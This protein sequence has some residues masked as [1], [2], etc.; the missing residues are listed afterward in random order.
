MH[1]VLHHFST[2]WKQNLIVYS[3]KWFSLQPLYFHIC[4]VSIIFNVCFLVTLVVAISG[5]SYFLIVSDRNHLY[6]SVYINYVLFLLR[7]VSIILFNFLSNAFISVP[8][9]FCICY[10]LAMSWLTCMLDCYI[11]FQFLGVS[12]HFLVNRKFSALEF[13]ILYVSV[14][15]L[16][17]DLKGLIDLTNYNVI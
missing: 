11:L 5:V 7:R 3:P 13:T 17:Q 4:Y 12:L 8:T 1:N 16:W 9:S 14:Q 15:L 2:I 6:Y 10:I